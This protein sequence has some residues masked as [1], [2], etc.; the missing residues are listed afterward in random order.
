M[1][2]RSPRCRLCGRLAARLENGWCSQQCR[3]LADAGYTS[4][5]H[6]AAALAPPTTAVEARVFI[7]GDSAASLPEGC[8]EIGRLRDRRR[9]VRVAADDWPQLEQMLSDLRDG[10]APEA[11]E[12]FTLQQFARGGL[13]VCPSSPSGEE[14]PT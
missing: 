14:V 2:D 1:S 9:I 12:I 8:V 6:P 13:T 4:P 5:T 11:T 10:A 3:A 7:E